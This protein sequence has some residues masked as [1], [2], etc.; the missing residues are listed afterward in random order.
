L[1]FTIV[2]GPAMSRFALVTPSFNQGAY[3][4]ACVDSVLA[5]GGVPVDYAVADGGSTDES[6]AVLRGYGDRVRWTSG[7]DGGQVRAI[8]A[9][10]KVLQGEFCGYLNSDDVLAP[11]ALAAVAEAF[12]RHPDV[13]VIYG[14]AWFIDAAGR[15][16]RPYPTLPWSVS[17]L[18]DHC[19]LC[20]PATFWRRRV[21]ERWGWF[22]PEFDTTFDYEFWLR[23][24]LGGA[25]FLHLDAPLAESREHPETK[26]TRARA[27][28][29]A[30]IRRLQLRHLGYCGRNWWEQ[31]LRFW[32]DESGSGWGRLVPG[33][34]DE[35]VYGL[36]WVPYALWRRRLGGHLF[37][38]EGD[39]R[40]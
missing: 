34:K 11:G 20:Q 3:L 23:L 36:A 10:L 5:Q 15:R 2:S 37:Y 30:E 9:G 4:R 7:P 12:A 17:H 16:T 31:Q 6:I 26:S 1:V 35:R 29:F 22:S 32:R 33:R 28:V 40:A 25:R 27:K 14:Q 21:H 8:N 24:A 13:D 18:V 19:F 39:W 38:R